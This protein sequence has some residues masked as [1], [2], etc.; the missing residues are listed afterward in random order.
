MTSLELRHY[1]NRK[2]ESVHDVEQP[3]G[4]PSIKPNG[5]N[6]GVVAADT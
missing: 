2:V 5:L 3:I 6:F 1:S 4:E